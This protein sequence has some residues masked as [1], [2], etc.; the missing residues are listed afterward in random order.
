MLAPAPV[1]CRDAIGRIGRR[2]RIDHTGEQDRAAVRPPAGAGRSTRDVGD[3]RCLATLEN[4]QDID[5]RCLIAF[6]SSAESDLPS[7]GTPL[8]AALTALGVRQASRGG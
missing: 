7:V 5:L 4:P 8:H 2:A 1:G 6:A 3:T